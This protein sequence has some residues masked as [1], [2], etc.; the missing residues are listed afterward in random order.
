M[1][2]WINIFQIGKDGKPYYEIDK[3]KMHGEAIIEIVRLKGDTE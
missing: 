3:C 2:S 1:D